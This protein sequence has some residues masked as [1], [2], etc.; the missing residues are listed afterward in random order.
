MIWSRLKDNCC[1]KCRSFL[2]Y[3]ALDS[4]HVCTKATCDFSISEKRFNE[5]IEDMYRPKKQQRG[6]YTEEDNLSALNNLGFKMPSM[7]Y[8][9]RMP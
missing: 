5:I 1:P 6:G 8:S 4:A 7:D 2:Q 3:K 9:D